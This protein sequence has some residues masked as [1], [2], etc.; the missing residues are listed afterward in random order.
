[1]DVNSWMLGFASHVPNAFAIVLILSGVFTCFFGYR[2]FRVVLGVT[3]LVAGGTLSWTLLTGAGYGQAVAIA[4]IVLGALLGALA[5]FSLFYVGVFL[6]GSALGLLMATVVLS[7]IDNQFNALIAYVFALVS[8]IV[9]L[10]FRK[11]LIVV[12]TAM[13]GAWSVL[14]GI[15]YFAGDMDLVR[16][17][18]QPDLLPSQG[19]CYY[20]ILALWVVLGTSGV[21][22]QMKTLRK[23]KRRF[24]NPSG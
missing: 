11:V 13:T 19:G 7:A 5:M 17:F 22:V 1:M 12:S 15:S 3:G 14:S 9:T 10:L 8:G 16:V 24:I 2:L 4:G 21:G 23:K 20:L 6:F 18:A